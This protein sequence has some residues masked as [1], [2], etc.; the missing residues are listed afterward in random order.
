L[1]KPTRVEN[2]DFKTVLV[3]QVGWAGLNMGRIDFYMDE[4]K[5]SQEAVIEL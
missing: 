5:A 4:A 3:N 2:L 1:E